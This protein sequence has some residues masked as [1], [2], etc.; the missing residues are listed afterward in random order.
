[1]EVDEPRG[2]AG[3]LFGMGAGVGDWGESREGPEGAGARRY[4]RWAS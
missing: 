3:A 4:G 2:V 1:M